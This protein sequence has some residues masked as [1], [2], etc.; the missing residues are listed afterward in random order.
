M[1]RCSPAVTERHPLR[2]WPQVAVAAITAL[3]SVIKNSTA[4][5]RAHLYI[6]PCH[7]LA[8]WLAPASRLARALA[9]GAH[10]CCLWPADACVWSRC[11]CCCCCC[12]CCRPPHPCANRRVCRLLQTMM[13]LEKELKDAAASLQRCNPT[14]ISLKAGC[15]LFLRWVLMRWAV[16]WAADW[17]CR[18]QHFF[19]LG[20]LKAGLPTGVPTFAL[21][22]SV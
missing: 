6:Q 18:A 12:C 15:E 4:Q 10:L 17:G 7:L 13:G 14:A 16:G 9:A 8:R 1:Q 3:T 11:R 2:C 19:P 21:Q 22:P 20:S 5:V